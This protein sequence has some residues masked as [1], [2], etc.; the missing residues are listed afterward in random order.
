MWRKIGEEKAAKNGANL[1]S[2]HHL[3]HTKRTFNSVNKKQDPATAV[4][5]DSRE[6]E[7]QQR[8][9]CQFNYLNRKKAENTRFARKRNVLQLQAISRR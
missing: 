7:S 9:K 1:I 6:I 8:E 3:P 4:A 5:S 2:C